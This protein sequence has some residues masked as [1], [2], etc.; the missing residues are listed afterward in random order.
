MYCKPRHQGPPRI[1]VAAGFTLQVI[2]LRGAPANEQRA[3]LCSTARQTGLPENPAS[4]TDLAVEVRR[5]VEPEEE[6]MRETGRTGAE[7][8]QQRHGPGDLLPA[9]GPARPLLRGRADDDH[10]MTTSAWHAPRRVPWPLSRL[11][12]AGDPM[13][14]AV[15]TDA[16]PETHAQPLCR[17]RR[18]KGAMKRRC[19]AHHQA[20]SSEKCADA[21]R[22]LPSPSP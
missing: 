11:A 6:L 5:A 22:Q 15:R 2:E 12:G 7:K 18:K 20:A 1:I 8:F 9:T 16:C 4:R 13:R 21:S 3:R 10:I 17:P 19:R 14:A